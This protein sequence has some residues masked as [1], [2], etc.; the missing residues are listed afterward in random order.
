MTVV[1]VGLMPSDEVGE[2]VGGSSVVLLPLWKS[3]GRVLFKFVEVEH[4]I[5]F[6]IAGCEEKLDFSEPLVFEEL[7]TPE[8]SEIAI[9]LLCT[10]I[11]FP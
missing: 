6:R 4:S 3:K 9:S 1:E 5:S 10:E 11:P 7:S 2:I 8:F